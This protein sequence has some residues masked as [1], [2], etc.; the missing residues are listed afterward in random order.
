MVY[1]FSFSDRLL[2]ISNYKIALSSFLNAFIEDVIKE[3]K[4]LPITPAR[5]HLEG[6]F[7]ASTESLEKLGEFTLKFTKNG[8]VPSNVILK[9]F[10]ENVGPPFVELWRVEYH[11]SQIEN[12]IRSVIDR[13]LPDGWMDEDK[14]FNR[15]EEIE[16][17]KRNEE[18]YLEK[19]SSESLVDYL[20]FSDY[21]KIAKYKD[22]E[23]IFRP[24]FGDLDEF[25]EKMKVLKAIRNKIAHFRKIFD[26]DIKKVDEI[27]KWLGDGLE[28]GLGLS[29]EQIPSQY[30][31]SSAN[32]VSGNIYTMEGFHSG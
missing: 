9:K 15:K 14:Y 25:E 29:R 21:Y 30:W 11:I 17:R 24:I 27:R 1:N 7:K 23:K 31:D 20:D 3:K 28:K 6:L 22:N 2:G 16:K 19:A 4:A 12:E 18:A 10:N 26:E 8:T 13:N 5:G 32:A